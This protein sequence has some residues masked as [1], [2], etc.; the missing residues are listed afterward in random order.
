[1]VAWSLSPMSREDS[2]AHERRRNRY[3]VDRPFH[4]LYI[5]VVEEEFQMSLEYIYSSGIIKT[6]SV[7]V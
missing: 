2:L 5:S 1:M 7:K 6:T 4:V 3:L